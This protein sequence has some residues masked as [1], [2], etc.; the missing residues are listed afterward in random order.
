MSRYRPPRTAGT[1]L[2]T[3]EGEARMRAEFHELWHVR[4]PQVTQAVSEA[5]AQG[6]RSE[7]AE[8]TYGKK[9]LREIDS[10]VRFLTKRLE[11]LKVVSEKPSDPNKVYFGAWVTVEDEDGK[12]SRYRIVG[13][14]ELDL[15][16]N[17]ISIDSPLARALIGKAL[18]AEVS[19][20]TPTGEK[21]VYIVDIAY[22]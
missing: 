16:Q 22:P 4:R 5:A 9:M 20:Q 19:V 1:A 7:N 2:I 18:D 14:D 6:D 10:R 21:R 12:E 11:A 8:Y 3:P 17:L 15:K 13:P